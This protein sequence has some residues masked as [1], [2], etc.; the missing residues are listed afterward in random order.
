MLTT[1][2]LLET[3]WAP[4]VVN[5]E[6]V[7]Q[8]VKLLR[9]A[10]GDD[11]RM[12]RYVV[13]VRGRGYRM[14]ASVTRGARD[15]SDAQIRPQHSRRGPAMRTR[16]GLRLGLSIA[17]AVVVLGG[18][19]IA[20]WRWQV[21]HSS[22]NPP[23]TLSAVEALAGSGR[24]R[25][26]RSIAVLPFLDLSERRDE[27]FFA[28]G[29]TEEI[30]SLLS[31]APDLR[32]SARTS[33]FYFK[34]RSL[35]VGQIGSALG[36]AHVLEGSVRKSG[37]RIRVTVQL[38]RTDTG[39][40]VWS[41]SY[42]R[43]PD[44][45]FGTQTEIAEAVVA[46]LQA[47]LADDAN[48]RRDPLSRNSKARNLYLAAA[49]ELRSAT[50]AGLHQGLAELQSAVVEDPDFAQ[51]WAVLAAARLLTSIFDDAPASQVRP[52]A[53]Q[54]AD[55][56]LAIDPTLAD[57]HVVKARLLAADWKIREALQESHQALE[58]D[59]N[60]VGALLIRAQLEETCGHY[61]EALRLGGEALARDPLNSS[62]YEQ[63]AQVLWFAGRDSEAIETYQT[64]IALNPSASYYHFELAVVQLT[65][66]DAKAALA[67]VDQGADD[68]ERAILRP[69]ML[70]AL[71]QH[72]EAEKEQRIAEQK[73]G[74]PA[75][76]DL[77]VFYANRDDADGALSLLEQC[78]RRH[79]FWLPLLAGDPLFRKLRSNPRFQALIRR[80]DIPS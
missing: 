13:G 14:D 45:L 80:F 70:D 33:A 72:A 38:I 19:G 67:S 40:H 78:Y 23:P 12:P 65:A 62:S 63:Q 79:D 46:H 25:S 10:L 66:G 52:L 2:E 34:D 44:D 50:H 68:E 21:M 59:P 35:P 26:E 48:R 58:A 77:A 47:S 7:A 37:D 3:V 61:D 49:L 76:H 74:A 22:V 32:V 29:M 55:R 17:A 53:L 71:G 18:V 69:V 9:Q 56:A 24:A 15:P 54:A 5:P 41:A 1:E 8:R 39:Y 16:R 36:V 20:G 57:A 28:D 6:T 42:D 11:P 51:A 31:Q 4:A 27:G 75:A 73:Y 43:R 30:T 60:H 64:A